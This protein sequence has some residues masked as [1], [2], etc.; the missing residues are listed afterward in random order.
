[1]QLSA[2]GRLTVAPARRFIAFSHVVTE[3]FARGSDEVIELFE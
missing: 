3:A 1:M 2:G